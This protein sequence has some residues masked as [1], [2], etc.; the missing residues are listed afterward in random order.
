MM[1]ERWRWCGDQ[2]EI[3]AIR[4]VFPATFGYQSHQPHLTPAGIQPP[5][6]EDEFSYRPRV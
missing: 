5:A 6:K 2:M 1:E 3:N 4:D